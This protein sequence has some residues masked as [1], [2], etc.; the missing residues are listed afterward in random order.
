MLLLLGNT[1]FSQD[2]SDLHSFRTDTIQ[3]DKFTSKKV[4]SLK[5]QGVTFVLDFAAFRKELQW[6]STGHFHNEI[7]KQLILKVDKILIKQ[8]LKNIIYLNN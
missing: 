7:I 5:Y 8:N 3:L 4:M 2:V 6:L 1:C